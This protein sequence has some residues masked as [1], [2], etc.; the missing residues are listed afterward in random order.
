MCSAIP[1]SSGCG[2]P[3]S[4]SSNAQECF[5]AAHDSLPHW[6]S[7]CDVLWIPTRMVNHPFHSSPSSG[8]SQSQCLARGLLSIAPP[9]QAG[10]RGVTTSSGLANVPPGSWA[11]LMQ[12]AS[13]VHRIS[14]FHQWLMNET[15]Q[16]LLSIYPSPYFHQQTVPVTSFTCPFHLFKNNF[17]LLVVWFNKVILLIGVKGLFL[18]ATAVCTSAA[19]HYHS[20]R[21]KLSSLKVTCFLTHAVKP[22]NDLM[23]PEEPCIKITHSAIINN[24]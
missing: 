21:F 15:S 17:S 8:L 14:H 12:S 6:C 19:P 18:L 24:Y 20:F 9:P 7:S 22:D 1:G 10:S 5:R 13:A 11:A 16:L 3:N 2:R 4:S 23:T